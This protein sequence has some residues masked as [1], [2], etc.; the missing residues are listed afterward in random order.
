M[1]DDLNP[2]L[3]RLTAFGQVLERALHTR[4]NG[5]PGA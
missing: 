3:A 1:P 4:N 5:D 2:L